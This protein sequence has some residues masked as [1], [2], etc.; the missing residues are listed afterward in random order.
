MKWYVKALL[1][2]GL[3]VAIPATASAQ[4][5]PPKHAKP[6]PAKP[7]AHKPTPAK[8]APA[9]PAPA[10]PGHG[11]PV[12]PP[13]PIMPPVQPFPHAKPANHPMPVPHDY[14]AEVHGMHPHDFA[15][16]L[17]Q[18]DRA[19]FKNDRIHHVKTAADHHKFTSE[20][21]RIILTHLE[22]ENNRI[23]A[24][25]ALYPAVVDRKNWDVVYSA[26]QFPHSRDRIHHCIR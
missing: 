9:K 17:N 12:P 10:K 1:A 2:A 23:D 11:A 16:L 7:G 3:A 6:A 26:L 18:I 25:C 20:Q 5:A 4:P 15:N 8:P 21:V 13:K 14:R 19:N 24:A 22:F